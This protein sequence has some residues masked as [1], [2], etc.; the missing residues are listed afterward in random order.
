MT[1]V[2]KPH[3]VYAMRCAVLSFAVCLFAGSLAAQ[4]WTS[5]AAGDPVAGREL[6]E[7]QCGSCHTS[8]ESGLLVTGSN[9]TQD[10]LA[11]RVTDRSILLRALHFE[12][13]PTMPKYLFSDYETN[14]IMA[15]FAQIRSGDAQQPFPRSWTR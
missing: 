15:Y 6:V 14:N 7:N 10:D 5:I 8:G 4:D 11:H 2:T 13:H 12:R 3:F 1:S 9:L